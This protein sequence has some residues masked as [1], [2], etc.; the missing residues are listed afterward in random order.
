MKKTIFGLLGLA[1]LGAATSCG[2]SKTGVT[3]SGASYEFIVGKPGSSLVQGDKVTL[4]FNFK[5]GDSV[6]NSSAQIAQAQGSAFEYSL[7]ALDS[8]TYFDGPM[9]IDGLYMLNKGD[10]AIFKMDSKT[11]F[12]KIGQSA[13]EW[14]KDTDTFAWEVKLVEVITA[15]S[16]AEK[17]SAL[18][19]MEATFLK[20][21]KNLEYKFIE[22]GKSDRATK[23][24]DVI[25]FNLIQK[26]GDS[27]MMNTLEQ[28]GKPISQ[29][30]MDARE[31][32]DL[33][34]GLA[35]MRAGD[36]ATFRI[37]LA[38]LYAQ[39][40]PK[41]DWMKDAEYISFDV[42]VVNVRSS[43]E[44]KA[45]EENKK[46][47]SV[48]ESDK[49]IQDYLKAANISDFKKT[50]SGLYYVVHTK[51]E[52]PVPANGQEVSVNYTGKL[53]N[54]KAFDSN[55]DPNFGH[56]EP[57]KVVVGQASVI[58]GWVEGLALFPKGSK[59]TLYIPS[60][61][62]YGENGAGRDIGPFEDL[63]FDME[64]VDVK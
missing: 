23:I 34:S 32:F 60:H 27:V 22:L 43:E 10:S 7:P 21:D 35:M 14:I 1:V 18:R 13:P 31:D 56:V 41:Q 62:A 29:P 50:E 28:Q 17:Y 51:G 11:F 2:G 33:M 5:V 52:G 26:I 47:N 59:V 57:F 12:T 48:A 16:V 61:L 44:V 25:E 45:E 9:P 8:N 15:K 42:D 20:T 55:I 46:K 4:D 58:K 38:A 64:I 3:K 6:L 30:L 63:I 24:G 37:P 36:K 39:G 40:M 19:K 54:G 53:M 49:K